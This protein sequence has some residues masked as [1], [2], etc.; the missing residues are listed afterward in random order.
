MSWRLFDI[1]GTWI[2]RGRGTLRLNDK[3]LENQTLQSRLVMRTQGSLRVI[4]NTKVSE[5]ISLRTKK[6]TN[7]DT[8]QMIFFADLGRY[9]SWQGEH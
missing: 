2:E 4:L 5:L 1:A 7:F 3:Q 8:I 9:D 6:L